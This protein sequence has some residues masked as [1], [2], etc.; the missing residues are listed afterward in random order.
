MGR[1][2][3]IM[4]TGVFI[5]LGTFQVSFQNR[6]LVSDSE[7]AGKAWRSAAYTNATSALETTAQ[8]ITLDPAW[9]VNGNSETIDFPEGSAFVEVHRNGNII[10][11][12]A[13]STVADASVQIEAMYNWS[14]EAFFPETNSAMGI[15][16]D[17]L[18]FNISGS[19]FTIT[20]HDH[21]VDGTLDPDGTSLPGIVVSNPDNLD[22]IDDALNDNQKN[23]ITGSN[24]TPSLEYKE[25]N[26]VDIDKVIELLS[27]NADE[28]YTGDFTAQ[29]SGSLGTSENPKIII[30]EGTLDVS[31]ATGAGV[32]VIKKG[33]E[34]DVRGNL[35]HYE[36]LIIVQGAAR[37]VRGNINVFG[38]MLFGGEDPELEIDIDLR[39]NV[40]IAYSSS[41]L[42][43]IE[44]ALS[45]R[46]GGKMIL[47]G[48]YQ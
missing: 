13:L 38:S 15:H 7:T 14:S 30:V 41:V 25:Y 37:L 1:A 35:D 17:N 26:T 43:Q 40:Y 21:L 23:N 28:Y 2:L 24:G 6:M 47:L 9:G 45:G 11:L 46:F 4:V 32:L 34:L 29:G 42:E 39:G 36:G 3:L 48:I 8:R 10:T 22:V 19:A 12:N 5:V 27:A 18:S 20:G 31:N 44:N 33:G 16:S